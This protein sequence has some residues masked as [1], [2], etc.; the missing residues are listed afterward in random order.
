MS[1][2]GRP[3]SKWHSIFVGQ[4]CGENITNVLLL[5]T[6]A[7]PKMGSVQV[8]MKKVNSLVDSGSLRTPLVT[9]HFQ[10][11]LCFLSFSCMQVNTNAGLSRRPPQ[12]QIHAQ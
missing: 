1:E 9:R 6:V 12:L 3:F 5:L 4:G 11:N 7:A 2:N 8:S 10:L